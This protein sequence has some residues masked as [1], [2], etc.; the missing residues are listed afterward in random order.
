MK[1]NRLALMAR[2]AVQAAAARRHGAAAG[3]RTGALAALLGLALVVGVHAGTGNVT[4]SASGG[5]GG[6]VGTLPASAGEGF[7]G[8]PVGPL[9]PW[10]GMSQVPSQGSPGGPTTGE[11]LAPALALRG[12]QAELDHLIASAYSPDG[13][14]W[15]H[16]ESPTPSGVRTITFHGNAI[17]LLERS[18]LR[19][20][21]QATALSVAPSQIPIVAVV[22]AA[23]GQHAVQAL[24]PGLVPLPLDRLLGAGLLANGVALEAMERGGAA[25]AHL[26]FRADGSR[27]LVE[28]RQ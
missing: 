20:N 1:R 10:N 15:F 23:G 2:A 18:A 9:D 17:V 12:T 14:G 16:L 3:F 26:T 6:G 5:P 11:V 25:T 4:L 8:M 27:I 21:A 7:D 19:A 22:T 13:T 24:T 28:Q